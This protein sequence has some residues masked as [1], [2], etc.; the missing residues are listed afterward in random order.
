MISAHWIEKDFNIL[1]VDNPGLLYDYYGFPKE[2]YELKYPTSST[3]ELR[4]QVIHTLSQKGL[5]LIRNK[6]WKYDHG[7]FIPLSILYPKADI[8]VVQISL[9]SN[10]NP[11]EH[12]D[13]GVKLGELRSK[14]FLI[15]GSGMSYHN[16][17][18]FG[19]HHNL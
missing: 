12:Y 1:D 5:N 11:E 8:P 18:G 3:K 9:K 7:T 14:G 17:G 10:F 15:V 6:E 16:M 4:E 19:N 13:L 2:S